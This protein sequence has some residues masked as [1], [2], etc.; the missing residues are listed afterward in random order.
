MTSNEER[1]HPAANPA[2]TVLNENSQPR[3]ATNSEHASDPHDQ[4]C[5]DVARAAK[6]PAQHADGPL[7]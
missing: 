7:N 5:P 3:E 2:R 1:K 6:E 4:P